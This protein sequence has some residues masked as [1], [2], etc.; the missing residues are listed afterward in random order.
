MLIVGWMFENPWIW[1]LFRLWNWYGWSWLWNVSF[2][3]LWVFLSDFS[4]TNI[5]LLNLFIFE[6]KFLLVWRLNFPK[7]FGFKQAFAD[8][9]FLFYIKV[10]NRR[11]NGWV[12]RCVF[13]LIN[14]TKMIGIN[15]ERS[16]LWVHWRVFK[17]AELFLLII[18]DITHFQ[19]VFVPTLLFL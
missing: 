16:P 9:T 18:V 8:D 7:R 14:R 4:L 3:I 13:C 10:H 12:F 1:I 2:M 15:P 11:D 6:P 19:V 5:R 17:T